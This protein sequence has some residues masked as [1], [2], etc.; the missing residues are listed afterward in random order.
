MRITIG[1][2]V[3]NIPVVT[4]AA[5][6]FHYNP[7]GISSSILRPIVGK[8]QARGNTKHAGKDGIN[9]EPSIYLRKEVVRHDSKAGCSP[10]SLG[11]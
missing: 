10:A 9:K 11:L 8:I 3:E 1:K 7:Y 4:I 2:F 5:T 6:V